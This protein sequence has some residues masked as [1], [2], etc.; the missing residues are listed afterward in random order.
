MKT[1]DSANPIYIY[2]YIQMRA[3]ALLGCAQAR[4][5][6]NICLSLRSCWAVGMWGYWTETLG[7][8]PVNTGWVRWTVTLTTGRP[9]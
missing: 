8:G 5:G 4:E 1:Y 9:T 7:H 3:L 2:I 6:K